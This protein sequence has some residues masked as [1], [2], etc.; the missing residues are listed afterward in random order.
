M[1]IHEIVRTRECGV[2][3]A[4][5]ENPADGQTV[6]YQCLGRRVPVGECDRGVCGLEATEVVE[7]RGGE[8][9]AVVELC[10]SC[11]GWARGSR[12]LEVRTYGK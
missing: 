7:L 10:G 2:C 5:I 6:C 3:D 9:L 8:G 4:A 11:L 1:N 12:K